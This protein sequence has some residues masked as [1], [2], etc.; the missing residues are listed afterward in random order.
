LYKPIPRRASRVRADA[1]TEAL[2]IDEDALYSTRTNTSV[3]R[4]NSGVALTQT[5]VTEEKHS[6]TSLFSLGF[7]MTAVGLVSLSVLFALII[8]NVIAPEVQKWHDNNTYGYPRTIHVREDVGHGGVS[9]FTGENLKGYLYVIEI[10]EGDPAKIVPHVYFLG[11]FSS[12]QLAITSITFVD[13]N[14]DNKLDMVVTTEN[15]T[16][17]ILYNDGTQFKPQQQ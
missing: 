5:K 7:C 12:D 11:H 2:P 10:E 3:R 16:I 1:T 17:Y 9:D 13:E 8:T 6:Q 14:G 4:Y 15:G